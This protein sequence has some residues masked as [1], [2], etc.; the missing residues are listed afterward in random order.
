[1]ETKEEINLTKC[2]KCQEI[3]IRKHN[4]YYPDLRNKKHIDEN[5]NLWVGLV[6]PSCVV[7]RSK[8][9]MSKLRSERKA[10]K[11]LAKKAKE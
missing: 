11:E 10:A 2:S 5:G 7:S 9:G 4:G 6:C 3:K 8:G 1:M